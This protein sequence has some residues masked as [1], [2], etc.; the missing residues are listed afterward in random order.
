MTACL[1]QKNMTCRFRNPV[2]LAVVLLLAATL[3]VLSAFDLE[4]ALGR[5]DGG[6]TRDSA[7]DSAPG[8]G[9]AAWESRPCRGCY[10]VVRQGTAADTG[11]TPVET[12]P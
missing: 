5:S 10:H 4:G 2:Y 1:Q 8:G 7:G 11:D 6:F 9:Q 3:A 12:E